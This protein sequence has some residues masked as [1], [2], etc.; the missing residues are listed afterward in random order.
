MH[1]R[2][3]SRFNGTLPIF[4]IIRWANGLQIVYRKSFYIDLNVY[5]QE[6]SRAVSVPAAF[7][8]L[9]H[10]LK[11]EISVSIAIGARLILFVTALTPAQSLT[12]SVLKDASTLHA[13]MLILAVTCRLCTDCAFNGFLPKLQWAL[14]SLSLNYRLRAQPLMPRAH[15]DHA[16]WSQVRETVH[17]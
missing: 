11:S 5:I 14:K 1:H 6:T 15:L 3:P 12:R 9:I 7:H 4:V 16:A 10:R 2:V 8:C 13:L 17:I